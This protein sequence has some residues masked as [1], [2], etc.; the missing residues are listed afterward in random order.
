MAQVIKSTNHEQ[1][2]QHVP[3]KRALC[4][5]T[6]MMDQRY[7]YLED[8]DLTLRHVSETNQREKE[9]LITSI[10]YQCKLSVIWS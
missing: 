3:A 6:T 5:S 2:M 8:E 10:K 7:G 9:R 4:L 1:S